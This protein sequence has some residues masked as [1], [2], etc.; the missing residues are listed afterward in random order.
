[1][2]SILLVL[3]LTCFLFCTDVEFKRTEL[4]KV[5][6]GANVDRFI[7]QKDEIIVAESEDN[8]IHWYSLQG[9]SLKMIKTSIL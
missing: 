3:A 1:M 4:F 9:A 2:K 7:V 5:K 8:T 6:K